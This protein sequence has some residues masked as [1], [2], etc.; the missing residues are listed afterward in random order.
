MDLPLCRWAE[1][2]VLVSLLGPA[3]PTSTRGQVLPSKVIGGPAVNK[4]Y[5]DL[6]VILTL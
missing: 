5:L 1:R 4:L 3:G 2:G 6:A